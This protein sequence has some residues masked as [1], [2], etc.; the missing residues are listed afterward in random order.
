[1]LNMILLQISMIHFYWQSPTRQNLET[2]L[3]RIVM[4][5][6]V[7]SAIPLCPDSRSMPLKTLDE[8]KMN[9]SM[10]WMAY[11]WNTMQRGGWSCNVA[12][13]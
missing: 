12:S 3:T 6:R 8:K 9:K 2:P 1:M 10:D 7:F 11:K 13:V 4:M 5:P